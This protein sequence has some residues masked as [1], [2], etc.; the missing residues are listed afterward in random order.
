MF[1]SK[2]LREIFNQKCTKI[3]RQIFVPTGALYVTEERLGGS[4]LKYVS[5]ISQVSLCTTRVWACHLSN[6]RNSKSAPFSNL[7]KLTNQRGYKELGTIPQQAVTGP[8][9]FLVL[10]PEGLSF[11]FVFWFSLF[12]GPTKTLINVA[13]HRFL[14]AFCNE[15]WWRVSARSQ[16]LRKTNQRRCLLN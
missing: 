6:W 7:A 9:F 11:T 3:N 13:E 1:W 4:C 10:V 15:C 5:H 8:A 12:T 14:R 2:D 16:G